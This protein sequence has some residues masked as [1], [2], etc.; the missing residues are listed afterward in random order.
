VDNTARPPIFEAVGRGGQ[1]IAILPKENIVVVFTGGG[2]NTDEIAP[3]LFRAIRSD[4]PIAE[5]AASQEKLTQAIARVTE[6]ILETPNSQTPR[7]A[8]II[9]GRPYSL[10]A[11]PI[12][13]RALQFEF[14]GKN[15]ATAVLRFDRETW[16][17]PVGLDGNR[18]FAPIGPNKLSVASVGRWTSDNEFVLD[19]D[20]VAN[21]NHFVF[22]LRFDGDKIHVRMN[23]TTGEIK[24]VMVEGT[25]ELLPNKKVDQ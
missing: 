24:D 3:F 15:T 23:E 2:A 6:P 5:N 18:Q 7:L 19:L 14:K 22:H 12:D 20:T 11:N 8:Q 16:A 10:S 9:S 13:L 21:V 17:V 1:R 25:A 4:G